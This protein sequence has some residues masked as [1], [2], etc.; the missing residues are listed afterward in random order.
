MSFDVLE[1]IPPEEIPPTSR[2][3]IEVAF[4][5]GLLN[6]GYLFV[7]KH[8]NGNLSIN[9]GFDGK[10]SIHEGLSIGYRRVGLPGS[11][12]QHVKSKTKDF[13]DLCRFII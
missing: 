12:D 6:E 7:F 2:A 3:D 13:V 5:G 10:S 8:S 1:D 11:M 4:I 9:R